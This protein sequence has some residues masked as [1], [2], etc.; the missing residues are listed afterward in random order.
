MN[1]CGVYAHQEVPKLFEKLDRRMAVTNSLVCAGLDPD[2]L[3]MPLSIMERDGTIE[4]KVLFFLK[5]IVNI[6]SP[7]VCAFKIQKAFFDQFSF[8]HDLLQDIVHYSKKEYP[9]I[10]VFLDCK[11][12]DTDNTM[13]TYMDLFFNKIGLDS[14]VINPN[15]GDD[16]LQPFLEDA[17]KS[18]IVLVQTSNP[19]GKVIQELVLENGKKLWEEVLDIMLER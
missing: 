5:K 4:E 17:Y 3:K 19:N 18:A 16:V 14:I 15:M 11:V 8:G 2:P 7:H 13:K 12:G 10:P 6:T 1:V 9:E